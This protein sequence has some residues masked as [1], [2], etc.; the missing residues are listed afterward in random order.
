MELI[1]YHPNAD[2]CAELERMTKDAPDVTVLHA[3]Y[4]ELHTRKITL[5]GK[6]VAAG[7]GFGIMD[8]GLGYAM[9]QAHGMRLQTLVQRAIAREYGPELPVGCAVKVEA[10][11]GQAVLYAPTMQVP[12]RITGTDNVYR[13]A[14]AA[15]HRAMLADDNL[16]LFMPLLG[17]G[18]GGM[19]LH[20][21]L[22]QILAGVR[23]GQREMSPADFTWE[24]ADQIHLQWHRFCG[25]PD[26]GVRFAEVFKEAKDDV[27][28]QKEG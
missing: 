10:D 3:S 7:N 20:D 16:R 14:R 19:S 24:H 22:R 18:A 9:R 21:A 28:N 2:V 23:D 5:C 6:V 12:M 26:D 13:A 27:G 8:G 15:T 11:D 4:E 1:L 25:I 17:T